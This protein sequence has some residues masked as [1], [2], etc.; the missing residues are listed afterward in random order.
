MILAFFLLLFGAL[1]FEGTFF[2]LPIVLVLLVIL[3][4]AY[5]SFW[6]L[7]IAFVV[8]IFL[9]IMLFRTIASSS[10][11]FLSVLGLI[12][13]YERRFEV[14]SY[15][16]LFSIVLLGSCAYLFLFGSVSFFVQIVAAE[17]FGAVL[18]FFFIGSRTNQGVREY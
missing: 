1:L 8:G 11:F 13:I 3:Q 5:R 12:G 2:A 15:P 17:I 18:F 4:V 14:R 16:F 9:D 6:V 7:V 10:L